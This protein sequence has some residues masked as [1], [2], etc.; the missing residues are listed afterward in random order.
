MKKIFFYTIIF[1]SVTM[2][3]SCS[4]KILDTKPLDKF[5]ELDVWTDVNL[6][7]GFVYSTIPEVMINLVRNPSDGWP[8]VGAGVD[9]L[10]DNIAVRD[11]NIV[12]KDQLDKFYDDKDHNA[13]NGFGTI[14]R[15][16]LIIEKVGASKGISEND[17][18]KL[19]AQ[20]KLLRALVYFTKARLYGKYII[21]D[22]VLT[23]NDDLK[24]QRTATIKETYDFI[25][26]DLAE[27]VIDLP[28]AVTPGELSKGAAYAL[29]AEVALHGAAYIETGKA[30]YYQ[31]AKEASENLF[32][33]NYELDKN[34]KSLFNDFDY[35]LTS[36]EIILAFLKH[37]DN[38]N[39]IYMNTPMQLDVPN[40]S[41]E[42]DKVGVVPALVESIEGWT[43]RWPSNE[44]VNDYLVIDND[45]V[46]KKWDQTSYYSDFE[47][48]G[49]W[50]SKAIYFNRDKRFYASVAY[51][52]TM[53]F[54]N[55]ITIRKNGNMHWESNIN[56]NWSMTRSGYYFRKG[57][58]E[59]KKLWYQDRTAYH[60][61]VLRLGRSYLNYAEVMLRLNDI[62]KAIEYINK[63]R[64][65]HGGL[66]ALSAGL[67]SVD[68]WKFYNIERRVDLFNENDRYWTLLRQGKEAGGIVIPELNSGQK[69]I[70]ISEDGKSFKIIDLP[71]SKTEN[72]RAFS[73]KRYLFPVPEGERQLNDKLDQNLGW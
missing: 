58:Y 66:P 5:S 38:S 28:E 21:V 17:K 23:F 59:Q 53:Y 46:A 3:Q 62:P 54:K 10:T 2:N 18:K 35:S 12:A 73:V 15:C 63:T 40:C 1:L 22:K 14:R 31:I 72:E 41:Q 9:D 24:L 25:L 26:K 16:N 67:S 4:D 65:D 50:V 37:P 51:D 34:Y 55:L 20:G 64:A 13:W 49:G 11:N 52:S 44:L 69:C 32:K 8:F 68:A 42:K 27:A 43:G 6:A 47:N 45:G 61:I 60:Q 30:D 57:I 7:Q 70:E 39:S 19:I 71:L 29:R 36:K 48:N 56:G 33:I